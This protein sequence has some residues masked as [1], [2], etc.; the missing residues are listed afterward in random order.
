ME[1]EYC[2]IAFINSSTAIIK[3]L[4]DYET[5]FLSKYNL[6]HFHAQYLA[7]LD[8]N[9]Q[10]TLTEL[11]ENI[12]VDKSNTTRA[13]KD[14]VNKQYVIK[15][16]DSSRKYMVELTPSGKSIVKT[17]RDYLKKLTTKV[18]KNFTKQELDTLFSL[19]NKLMMGVKNVR[20][21]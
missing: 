2:N 10:M 15:V 18:F 19:L 14:L 4:R 3:R 13:I 5:K 12:G 16:G 21:N 17:F 7:N 8:I 20:D 6:T 11:S 9:K 1:K